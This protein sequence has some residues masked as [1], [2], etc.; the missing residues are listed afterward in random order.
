MTARH[1][2]PWWALVAL[3][4]AVLIVPSVA[5]LTL[6]SRA[7]GVILLTAVVGVFAAEALERALAR[8]RP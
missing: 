5:L 6:G 8:H 1:P 4:A 2:W 3:A 7:L